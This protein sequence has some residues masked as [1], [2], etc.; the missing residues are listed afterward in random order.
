[1]SPTRPDPLPSRRTIAVLGG[2]F[3]PWPT[4]DAA[5]MRALT[6]DVAAGEVPETLRIIRPRPTVVFGRQDAVRPSFPRAVGLARDAGYAVVQRLVGARTLAWHEGCLVLEHVVPDPDAQDHLA[7]RF[8]ETSGLVAGALRNV[9]VDARIG[10]V[11]GEP[12]PGAYSVNARDER[13]LASIDQRVVQGATYVTSTIVVTRAEE[14]RDVLVDVN[15]AL[16]FVWDPI[17]LGSVDEEVDDATPD[18][19]LDALEDELTNRHELGPGDVPEHTRHLARA[20]E[21][22]HVI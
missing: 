10:E 19:V 18:A 4:Y 14:L 7:D 1:M 6:L 3:D 15:E 17:R 2:A 20:L 11:P 16:G 8:V 13:K 21:P 5:L 9:G 12:A 22:E